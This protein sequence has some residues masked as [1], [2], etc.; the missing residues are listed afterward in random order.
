MK[1]TGGPSTRHVVINYEKNDKS[2]Q[3]DVKFVSLQEIMTWNVAI[4]VP[5]YKPDKPKYGTTD[6]KANLQS[7]NIAAEGPTAD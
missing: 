6:T 4:K 2:V 7:T 1:Q 5:I 3:S